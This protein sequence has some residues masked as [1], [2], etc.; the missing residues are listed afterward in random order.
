MSR[1]SSQVG[2][3]TVQTARALSN[4]I[5]ARTGVEHHTPQVFIIRDGKV[6]WTATHGRITA[7]RVGAALLEAMGQ[8]TVAQD[9]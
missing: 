8:S 4:E 6:T 9:G 2:L 7:E 5:E 1:I 3:V